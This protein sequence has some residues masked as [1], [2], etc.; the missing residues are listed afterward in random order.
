MKSVAI[1][2]RGQ[3]G[4]LIYFYF[5]KTFD[6]ISHSILIWKMRKS[7][8]DDQNIRQTKN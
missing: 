8:L 3:Q 6:T 7:E 5:S 1:P 2:M 4:D